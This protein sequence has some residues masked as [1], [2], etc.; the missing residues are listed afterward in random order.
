M[1]AQPTPGYP[2]RPIRMLVPF[3]PGGTTDILARVVANQMG[4]AWSQTVI[5]DNRPGA[6]GI[7]A[8]ETTAKSNA[9]GYTL[10]YVAIGHAINSLIYRKLPYD[11]ERDFTPISLG[12]TFAQLV[13]VHP[14]V[15]A[16]SVKELLALARSSSK[17]LNYASG[18]VGSSQHLAGALFAWS[19]KVDIGH[20]PYKGGAPGLTDL[21][22]RNVD[23]MIIQPNSPE[24]VSGG[25]VRALAVTSPKRNAAWPDLPTV[26][27][28]GLPGYES[29]AWYGLVGPRNLPREVLKALHEQ[30]A[31]ALGAKD[32]RQR[33]AAQGGEVIASS[34][35]EFAT[36]IRR[37]IDRYAKVV[38]ETGIVAE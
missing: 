35:T 37:E 18:G 21:M 11:T 10:L 16:T 4:Q 19:G 27:E 14:G 9:D 20:V 38:R 5:V 32:M 28:A 17:G 13:L 29:Q 22:A 33:I 30:A 25:R 12:A 3:A 26:A 7:I 2:A 1:H 34:P 31:A 36:F 15:A 24:Q 23:M 6:N 8:S